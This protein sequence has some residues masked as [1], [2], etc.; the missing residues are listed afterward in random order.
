MGS[1]DLH[2]VVFLLEFPYINKSW[3]LINFKGKGGTNQLQYQNKMCFHTEQF[4]LKI[5]S[6]LLEIF[7]KIKVKTPT[8][9]GMFIMYN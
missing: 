6:F 7:L 5:I 8:P 3:S 1:D 2:E 9:V 4:L